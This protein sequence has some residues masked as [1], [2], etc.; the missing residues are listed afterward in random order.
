[1]RDRQAELTLRR[2][3]TANDRMKRLDGLLIVKNT[4]SQAARALDVSASAAG[5]SATPPSAPFK[6]RPLIQENSRR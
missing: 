6:T 2:S 5:V 4:G 3:A 1:M